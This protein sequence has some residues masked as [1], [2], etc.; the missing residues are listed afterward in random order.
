M[1]TDE[2][3]DSRQRRLIDMALYGANQS[4]GVTQHNSNRMIAAMQLTADWQGIATHKEAAAG[5]GFTVQIP[6][7][8]NALFIVH[9]LW[10]A[11]GLTHFSSRE[12]SAGLA[13]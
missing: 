10:C 3:W 1:Q 4:S 8:A 13:R 7:I 11:A 12:V 5:S 6:C 2:L 9:G